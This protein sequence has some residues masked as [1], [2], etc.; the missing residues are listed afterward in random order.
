MKFQCN[1]DGYKGMHKQMRRHL[2][3]DHEERMDESVKKALVI[4]VGVENSGGT[5]M[6]KPQE[7]EIKTTKKTSRRTPKPASADR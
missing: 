3:K 2:W 1:R 6:P 5:P 4:Q 7:S